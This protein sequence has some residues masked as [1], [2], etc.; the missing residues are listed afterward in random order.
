MIYYLDETEVTI[1]EKTFIFK[2]NIEVVPNRYNRPRKENKY[3]DRWVKIKLKKAA[4]G[5]GGGLGSHLI[6]TQGSTVGEENSQK[7][8]I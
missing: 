1:I 3:K 6:I 5:G 7:F 4:S 2:H 8:G